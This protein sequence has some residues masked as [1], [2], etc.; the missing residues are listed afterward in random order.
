MSN[1]KSTMMEP[2]PG[3]PDNCVNTA[4]DRFP[5]EAYDYGDDVTPEAVA[6]LRP[7]AVDVSGDGWTMIDGFGK[8]V[9]A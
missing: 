9:S 3:M 4:E 7:D 8:V 1:R 5:P 2:A 6:L